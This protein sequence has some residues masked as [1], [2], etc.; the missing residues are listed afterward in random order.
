MSA[1]TGAMPSVSPV[2]AG[3]ALIPPTSAA[4]KYWLLVWPCRSGCPYVFPGRRCPGPDDLIDRP[5]LVQ[6]ALLDRVVHGVAV[7]SAEEKS[8]V[9]SIKPRT[10]S[11]VWPVAG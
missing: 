2:P 6:G 9:V 1:I 5:Q 10:I 7:E 3:A 4:P 8:S 11:E